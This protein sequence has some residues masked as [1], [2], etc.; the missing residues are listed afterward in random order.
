[1]EPKNIML[2][3]LVILNSAYK[4]LSLY[5]RIAVQFSSSQLIGFIS[6]NYHL[7]AF[8][9]AGGIINCF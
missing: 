6:I 9:M 1:V 4:L 3:S 8:S 7:S 5:N 2:S